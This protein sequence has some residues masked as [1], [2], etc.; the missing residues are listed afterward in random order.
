MWVNVVSAN[1]A[2]QP[3][4][5]ALFGEVEYGCT[6]LMRLLPE[7]VDGGLRLGGAETG[8]ALDVSVFEVALETVVQSPGEL[9]HLIDVEVNA[10]GAV[11]QDA[12]RDEGQHHMEW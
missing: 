5:D 10:E 8:G 2:Q 4:E 11:G 1:E 7:A 12:G 3:V 6:R 9:V